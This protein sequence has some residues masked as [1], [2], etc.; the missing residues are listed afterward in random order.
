MTITSPHNPF[1]RHCLKL[2]DNR[3]RR[4]LGQFLID[5]TSEISRAFQ[6]GIPIQKLLVSSDCPLSGELK[7]QVESSA[8][9]EVQE[10][11]PPLLNRLCYGQ[12]KSE[13]VA[14]AV[15]PEW[16]LE[17][18]ALDEK[19]LVLVLDQV[20]KPGNLGACVRTA[21][22]CGCSAVLLTR[23]IGDPFSSNAIRASRGAIFEVP[24][25]QT[26]PESVIDLASRIGATVFTASLDGKKRLWDLSL[27]RGAFVVFGNEAHGL[28]ERWQHESVQ[29]F[30]I[31]MLGSV[32]SLNVSIS[33]AVTLYEAVRQKQ[34]LQFD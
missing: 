9:I 5:G 4:R 12:V 25:A 3:K 33:A 8:G 18:I 14:L 16:S 27:T 29:S 6:A 24:M 22:A 7:I 26:A 15:Q 23:P 28:D 10:F 34:A 13:P 32:D 31:P 19:S 20:E 11:S 21:V 17:N 30:Q 2:R 1:Y